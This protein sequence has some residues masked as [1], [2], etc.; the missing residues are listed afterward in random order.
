MSQNI[1]S[2]APA[3]FP[4][5]TQDAMREQLRRALVEALAIAASGIPVF[6]VYPPSLSGGCSCK[7]GKKCSSP[8]KHPMI[9]GGHTKASTNPTTIQRWYDAAHRENLVGCNWGVVMGTNEAP[10]CVIDVD[11]K[12]KGGER[13]TEQWA[14][15]VEKEGLSS[16]LTTY[17]VRT[18]NGGF[19][20][21]FKGNLP[22]TAGFLPGCDTRGCDA[23][24]RR[25]GYVVGPHS[26][27]AS[28]TVYTPADE[29]GAPAELPER[30]KEVL[31]P[32]IQRGKV[33]KGGAPTPSGEQAPASSKGKVVDA[34]A[35]ISEGGRNDALFRLACRYRA[36]RLPVEEAR[37]L[38][39]HHN[40]TR[41][42]PTLDAGEVEQVLLS[43]YS[44]YPEGF[45]NEEGAEGEE[46]SESWKALLLA[47]HSEKGGVTYKNTLENAVRTLMHSPEW[48]G[49][50]RYNEEQR[51]VEV[52][53]AEG[54][55]APQTNSTDVQLHRYMEREL[56]FSPSAGSC[57]KALVEAAKENK[58]APRR[59]WLD[60]L[61][62]DGTARLGTLLQKYLG[63]ED[64]LLYREAFI[65]Q[66]I[67]SVARVYQPGC[68]HDTMLVLQGGQGIRKSSFIRSLYGDVN[69][70]DQASLE[71]CDNKD[72]LGKLVGRWAVEFAELSGLRKGEVEQVKKFITS[73]EDTFRPPYGRVMETFKRSCVLWGTTNE[74]TPLMDST[75]NRRFVTIPCHAQMSEEMKAELETIRDQLWAEAV[76]LY[77]AGNRWWFSADLDADLTQA[78]HVAAA[79]QVEESPMREGILSILTAST[80]SGRRETSVTAAALLEGLKIQQN[81]RNFSALKRELTSLRLEQRSPYINGVRTRVYAPTSEWEIKALT[82]KISEAL[83]NTYGPD[84]NH[85]LLTRTSY[86]NEVVEWFVG[87][88]QMEPPTALH[89]NAILIAVRAVIDGTC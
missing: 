6:P 58:V 81:A 15:L 53:D 72:N 52:L 34:S 10:I 80:L 16:L 60:S 76:A 2:S 57:S 30:L 8:A 24:G 37:V 38:V 62:W 61:E 39:H 89:T 27:H 5:S 78:A 51:E 66:M 4:F 56:G 59:S 45:Q 63:A 82:D 84:V 74:A 29:D 70:T 85:H 18:S 42:V 67:A 26:I 13:G 20:L 21:Y 86:P 33:T 69:F 22:Q 50:V 54:S 87:L 46:G 79:A 49:R 11:G 7:E 43:A 48:A 1:A 55:W 19:H 77:K 64:T 47:H 40:A 68:Q 3:E 9:P 88:T 25:S 73:R 31:L 23:R 12:E 41:C 65:R 32:L 35:P 14:R 83:F 44:R 28:G 71:Q 17:T 75:G 36:L